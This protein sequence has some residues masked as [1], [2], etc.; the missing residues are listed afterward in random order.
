MKNGP[1]SGYVS[2]LVLMSAAGPALGQLTTRVSVDSAGAQ[3][4]R[5]SET[6]SISADGTLVA[7]T[8]LAINL[9]LGDI[10]G[11]FDVFVHASGGTTTR[12]SV[13]ATGVQG[14]AES[15]LPALSA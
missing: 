12:V 14:N 2:I 6:A 15:F 5:S 10:N 9:V 7:F 3:G 11:T 4:N 1:F 13:S 8:S